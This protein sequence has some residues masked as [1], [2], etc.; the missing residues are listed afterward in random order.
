MSDQPQSWRDTVP[1]ASAQDLETLLGTGVG[2]AQEQ[3]EGQ[4]GFLPFALVMDHDGEVRLMAVT[5]ADAA[6]AT[7]DAEFDADAMIADL[8]ALLQQQRSGFRAAAI[9]CDIMLVE[10]ES[11]AVHVAAEHQDG[12]LFAA[13]LPYAANPGTGEWVFGDLAADTNDATIWVD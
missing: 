12:S 9:V 11:D 3:L 5:P 1:E 7:A 2:A 4:G 10:E 8:T 13:V 6:E